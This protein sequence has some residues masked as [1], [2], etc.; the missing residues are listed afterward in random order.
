MKT[1]FNS[2]AVLPLNKA[3]EI[4]SMVIIIRAVFYENNKY[5]LQVFSQD[6]FYKV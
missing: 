5:Y 3:I 4:P 2:D 1:K 6:A